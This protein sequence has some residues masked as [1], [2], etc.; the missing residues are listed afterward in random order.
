MSPSISAFSCVDVQRSV[1][2]SM[3]QG[4][5]SSL[6]TEGALPSNDTN[7]APR[8]SRRGA[9]RLMRLV[10]ASGRRALGGANSVVAAWGSSSRGHMGEGRSGWGRFSTGPP[11]ALGAA[12]RAATRKAQAVQRP[13]CRTWQARCASNVS[14]LIL[15]GG[16]VS[17][18][19]PHK[20]FNRMRA[21][22][23]P[24]SQLR[25]TYFAT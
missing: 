22:P 21:F 3:A 18:N 20:T 2:G 15:R 9:F 24:A 23:P 6:R 13:A 25:E 11:L 4:G 12:W 17:L 19:P 8:A 14:N 5:G 1:L 7:A 16:G 10:C